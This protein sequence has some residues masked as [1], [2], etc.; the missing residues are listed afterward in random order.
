MFKSGNLPFRA[1]GP[2]LAA[3]QQPSCL[4]FAEHLWCTCASPGTSPLDHQALPVQSPV[5]TANLQTIQMI[6]GHDLSR[7]S[8]PKTY[9]K[10]WVVKFS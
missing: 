10:L 6:V 2:E 9:V 1:K 4:F 5:V 7:K 3:D 8:Q